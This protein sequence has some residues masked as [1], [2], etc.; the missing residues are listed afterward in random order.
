MQHPPA[1]FY[2]SS[3][4]ISGIVTTEQDRRQENTPSAASTSSFL[5]LCRK[6]ARKWMPDGIAAI[7][8][9]RPSSISVRC[10]QSSPRRGTR[11]HGRKQQA[12]PPSD[13][14]SRQLRRP[15]LRPARSASV[16]PTSI[17][18]PGVEI[19]PTVCIGSVRS[20][21]QTHVAEIERH[22]RAVT[23][24]SAA[25]ESAGD[26]PFRIGAP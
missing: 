4:V 2:S 8:V 5:I 23:R 19:W 9:T 1:P 12:F 11:N 18:A 7:S 26:R 15:P 17:I 14:G 13:A 22:D 24:S 25:R 16:E 3:I 21:G 10:G 6:Q 20:V